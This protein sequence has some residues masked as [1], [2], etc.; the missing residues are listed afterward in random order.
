MNKTLVLL[1]A[2]KGSRFGGLK[3]L[4]TFQPQNATLAEFAI[5]DALQAGFDHFVAIVSEETHSDFEHVFQK[6]NL[7]NCS[8]CILQTCCEASI[9][10]RTK[11]WGTGHALYCARHAIHTPFVIVNGD[12]FYG[13]SA[14]RLA[15]E[16]LERNSSDF[17]LIGYPLGKTLSE[18]GYVSRALCTLENHQVVA[19]NECLNIQ[20]INGKIVSTHDKKQTFLDDKALVSMN[21][22]ILQPSILEHLETAW[23]KFLEHLTDPLKQ[24]FYLP[25]AIQN[26]AQKNSISIKLIENVSDHWLGITY[27]DD[28]DKVQKTLLKLTEAHYYPKSFK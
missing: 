27:A 20:R 4:Q 1:A 6:L 19:L 21:F 17:A 5:W 12:D 3:Q 16:F 25:V 7:Q 26:I 24:E 8:T 11:P 14:Y 15:A 2:G 13:Q 18:N 23:G 9:S 28:V 22:W 10:T